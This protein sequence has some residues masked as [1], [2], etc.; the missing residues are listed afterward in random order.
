M[1]FA[2]SRCN[3]IPTKYRTMHRSLTLWWQSSEKLLVKH[4]NDSFRFCQARSVWIKMQPY[5]PVI[6][7]GNQT[8]RWVEA[9][10]LECVHGYMSISNTIHNNLSSDQLS[11]SCNCIGD[12]TWRSSRAALQTACICNAKGALYT[13]YVHN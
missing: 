2:L 13:S 11:C 3:V 9:L 4:Q 7:A 10:T 5:F 1:P 8:N 6:I 12:E